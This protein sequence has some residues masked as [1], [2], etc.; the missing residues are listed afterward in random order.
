MSMEAY[1]VVIIQILL[2][3]SVS[4]ET[5]KENKNIA[6]LILFEIYT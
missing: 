3:H 5:K 2:N 6:F 4:F 1:R